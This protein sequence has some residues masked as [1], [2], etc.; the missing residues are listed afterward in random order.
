LKL[1]LKFPSASKSHRLTHFDEFM[2]FV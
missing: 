1:S 2:P